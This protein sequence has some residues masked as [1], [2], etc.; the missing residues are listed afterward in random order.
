MFQ[1]QV[2]AAIT[3]VEMMQGKVYSFDE[4]ARLLYDAT[5]PHFEQAYFDSF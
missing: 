3:K 4:E 5:P 1:K 2:L